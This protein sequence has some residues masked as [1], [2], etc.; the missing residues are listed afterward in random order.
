MPQKVKKLI[1]NKYVYL[2]L[3]I[4]VLILIIASVLIIN[5]ITKSKPVDIDT[6]KQ[7]NQQQTSPAS[8]IKSNSDATLNG[9]QQKPT[10]PT[11]PTLETPRVR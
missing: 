8:T 2:V 1:T 3:A 6:P 4:A 11:P 10:A 5:N 7:N 9:D